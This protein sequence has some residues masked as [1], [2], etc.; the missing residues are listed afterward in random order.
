M[1]TY[2]T[3]VTDIISE[4]VCDLRGC[5]EAFMASEAALLTVRGNMY[6]NTCVVKGASFK[7]EAIFIALSL[8]S[9]KG[10]CPLVFIS[11]TFTKESQVR[12]FGHF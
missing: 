10:H 12:L 2:V 4:V 7:S 8:A 1:V 6:L 3:E 5:L 11:I 9:L